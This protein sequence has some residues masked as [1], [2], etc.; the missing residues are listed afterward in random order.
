MDL[1]NNEQWEAAKKR[2][3]IEDVI[4]M[5]YDRIFRKKWACEALLQRNPKM[6]GAAKYKEDI[7][8]ATAQMEMLIDLRKHIDHTR[9]KN[10][11]PSVAKTTLKGPS[12]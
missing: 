11:T 9:E 6:K 7:V 2:N 4:H 5:K 1:L 12:L 8:V 3:T 10:I